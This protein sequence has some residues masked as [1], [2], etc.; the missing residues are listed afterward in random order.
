MNK[1]W[2]YLIIGG[3]LEVVWAVG[4][5]YS[6]GFTDIP[7]TLF[8]VTIMALSFYFFAYCLTHMEVGMAYAIYTGIGAVGTVLY[9]YFFLDEPMSILKLFFLALLIASIVGLK[10]VEGAEES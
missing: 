6:H 7:W 9:G 10:F 2:L 5:K 4:L 8:T 1:S 3:L